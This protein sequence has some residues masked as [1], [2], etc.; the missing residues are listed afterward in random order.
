MSRR[1]LDEAA[2]ETAGL[3]RDL[4]RSFD[5]N[6]E[7]WRVALVN[8]AFMRI[9][10]NQIF[11]LKTL[12]RLHRKDKEKRRERSSNDSLGSHAAQQETGRHPV[13]EPKTGRNLTGRLPKMR[14]EKEAE[15]ASSEVESEEEIH[16]VSD[17]IDELADALELEAE[18]TAKVGSGRLGAESN[19]ADEAPLMRT[20]VAED[21]VVS[22]R[23]RPAG[24]KTSLFQNI[25]DVSN[26]DA[27]SCI[28]EMP[29]ADLNQW[30]EKDK[31]PFRIA[32]SH[33]FM[34][35]NAFAPAAFDTIESHIRAM[36]FRNRLGV[37]FVKDMV[38]P[39]VVYG[40]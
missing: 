27:Q 1:P 31:S 4:K 18:T 34:N 19:A 7:R 40:K 39:V 26:S 20:L 6:Q 32:G 36:G 25:E 9:L 29:V 24:K 23:E 2:R 5:H 22:K 11:I 10:E 33:V 12:S 8:R 28:A 21:Q 3:V 30:I 14:R 17:L 15:D 37:L 13:K 16:V 35:P 38:S